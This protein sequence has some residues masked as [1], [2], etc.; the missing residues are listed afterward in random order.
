MRTYN[1]RKDH[2]WGRGKGETSEQKTTWKLDYTFKLPTSNNS[3]RTARS[4][5][6]KD[7]PIAIELTMYKDCPYL[8]VKISGNNNIKD[9]FLRAVI[10]SGIASDF[11]SSTGAFE[12]AQRDCKSCPEWNDREKFTRDYVK[13]QSETDGGLAILTGNLHSFEH[14]VNRKGEIALGLI[15][16]N[17]YILGFYETPKDKTWIVPENQVQGEFERKFAIMPCEYS[18]NSIEEIRTAQVFATPLLS[19]ADSSSIDKFAGG[20]PCVQD[21]D[22]SEIFKLPDP[23]QGLI[24]PN[25]M[26]FIDSTNTNLLF[27]T[28]KMTEVEDDFILRMWN[29]FHKATCEKIKFA[30]SF[31]NF[32]TVNFLEKETASLNCENNCVELKL[33]PCEIVSIKIHN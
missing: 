14:F 9:H 21:S 10:R 3:E 22:V 23:Y 25:E 8:Q 26:S 24:L 18:E 13:I 31:N 16:S 4:T 33:K 20:R 32:K 30:E 27:S 17:G 5:E 7:M 6:L 2:A 1:K 29:P 19:Y 15:R 12:I 28:I 11:S